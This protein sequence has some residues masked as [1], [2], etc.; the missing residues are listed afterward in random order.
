MEMSVV[1]YKNW[2]FTKQALPA[3]VLK[4]ST[5]A[6]TNV[7]SV[8]SSRGKRKMHPKVD[9]RGFLMES[10]STL[11]NQSPPSSIDYTNADNARCVDA[12][13][14]LCSHSAQSI[15]IDTQS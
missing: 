10:R 5:G 9:S 7:H 12:N 14:G 1:I 3:D 13:H 8:S 15:S 2:N 11:R 6:A 4:R